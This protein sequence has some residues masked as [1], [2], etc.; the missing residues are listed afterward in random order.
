VAKQAVADGVATF[1]DVD[2]LEQRIEDYRWKPR[3]PEIHRAGD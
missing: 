2:G 3:Y 1:T